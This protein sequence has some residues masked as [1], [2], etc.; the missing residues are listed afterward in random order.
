MRDLRRDDIADSYCAIEYAEDIG[1]YSEKMSDDICE[2][3]CADRSR[4]FFIAHQEINGPAADDQS[5]DSFQQRTDL[6]SVFETEAFRAGVGEKKEHATEN[7]CQHC[8]Y[9]Q[10]C[11]AFH[12]GALRMVKLKKKEIR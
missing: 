3:E 9:E 5:A 12:N 8:G 2:Q 6:R 7:K 11:R 1:G 10:E 4:I